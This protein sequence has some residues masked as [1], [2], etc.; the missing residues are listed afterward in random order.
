[1]RCCQSISAPA[2][3]AAAARARKGCAALP[4]THDD[5]NRAGRQCSPQRGSQGCTSIGEDAISDKVSFTRSL[6]NEHHVFGSSHSKEDDMSWKLSYRIVLVMALLV[7]LAGCT[8]ARPAAQAPAAA[9]ATT[10]PAAE[11]EQGDGQVLLGAELGVAPGAPVYPARL[12]GRLQG[13]GPRLRA[14][15]HGREHHRGPRRPG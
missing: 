6:V 1:M 2:V 15:H 8:A 3:Q 5:G 14:R 4:A 13:I 12:P 10:A 9:E 11:G 7:V